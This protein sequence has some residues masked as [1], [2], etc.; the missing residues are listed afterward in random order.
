MKSGMYLGEW[1]GMVNRASLR[2]D[3]SGEPWDLYT[4]S[5]FGATRLQENKVIQI[6][7]Y[8]TTGADTNP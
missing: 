6:L 3:L 8:D 4:A 7:A 5:S 2:N 1:K